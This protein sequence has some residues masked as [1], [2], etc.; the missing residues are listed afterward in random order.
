M[1]AWGRLMAAVAPDTFSSSETPYREAPF[2]YRLQRRIEEYALLARLD[3]PV[4]TWLLLWPASVGVVDRRR[5]EARSRR[6]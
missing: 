6:S 5:R 1:D 4:G 2:L 3:Q